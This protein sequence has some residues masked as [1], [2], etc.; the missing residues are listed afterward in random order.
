MRWDVPDEYLLD[1]EGATKQENF[2]AR[3]KIIEQ[4][5]A[6]FR[7]KMEKIFHKTGIPIEYRLVFRSKMR[8]E[9][10]KPEEIDAEGPDAQA[11][12]DDQAAL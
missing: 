1:I 12:G 5:L 10:N 2:E 6:L 4:Q 8:D 9:K 11:A 7:M 3:Q